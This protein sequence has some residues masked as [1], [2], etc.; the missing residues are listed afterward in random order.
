LKQVNWGIIGLG[1][2]ASKFADAFKYSKKAKLLA[3]ASK[4]ENKIQRYRDKFD[5]QKNYCFNNYEK[6]I[7]SD[8]ID[9]VYIALPNSLHAEWVLKCIE[10]KK[11]ILV[12][13]PA[14]LNI[15]EIEIIKK[16]IGNIFFSE[17]FMYI[18]H[19]QI[20][21]VVNLIKEGRIGNLISMNTNF[22]NDIISKK[23]F[24]G[25]KT[26]KRINTKNRLFNKELGGGA[27][28]DL[29]C[30]LTSFSL[31]IGFLELNN[32]SQ[33]VTIRNS[34]KKLISSGVDI[35]SSAELHF[36]NGFTSKIKV[37]FEENLG[38]KSQIIGTEGSIIIPQTWTAKNTTLIIDSKENEKIEIGITG[39]IYTREIEVISECIIKNKIKPDFPGLSIDDTFQNTKILDEWLKY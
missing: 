21:K 33:K 13:K 37:S 16:K 36:E 3:V 30:Y 5:I 18:Y 29:G 31:L 24:F 25:F 28:L 14:V 23:N 19:P 39:N 34:K 17:A 7:K 35:H 10:N 8:D 6:L 15:A 1:T 22:G 9:I 38:Q 32:A 2:I 20:L 27:I 4:D 26:R 12:E 11:K